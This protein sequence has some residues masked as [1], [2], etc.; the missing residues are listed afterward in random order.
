MKCVLRWIK[1]SNCYNNYVSLISPS[2]DSM[3]IG[4]FLIEILLK[5][6]IDFYSFNMFL[7]FCQISLRFILNSIK[8]LIDLHNVALY[9]SNQYK[10][11]PSGSY[12]YCCIIL[13]ELSSTLSSMSL[14][15]VTQVHLN[16]KCYVAQAN[17][18][19]NQ[20]IYTNPRTV[21]FRLSFSHP[22]I[23][24]V[25]FFIL[26]FEQ[27]ILTNSIKFVILNYSL[28]NQDDYVFCRSINLGVLSFYCLKYWQIE[29]YKSLLKW[30]ESWRWDCLSI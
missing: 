2:D 16:I 27:N 25:D 6:L 30:L 15:V 18:P 22:L 5:R 1:M 17:Q 26:L 3:E 11:A 28:Q 4:C 29:K 7:L 9:I 20:L 10:R 21:A 8:I 19:I 23:F 12:T 14:Y 24:L 13:I